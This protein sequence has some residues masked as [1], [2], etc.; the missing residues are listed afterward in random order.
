[1]YSGNWKC[2]V[3]R[4]DASLL[5]LGCFQTWKCILEHML[6]KFWLTYYK[7]CL[8]GLRIFFLQCSLPS[9]SNKTPKNSCLWG[10]KLKCRKT[11]IIGHVPIFTRLQKVKYIIQ[12]PTTGDHRGHAIKNSSCQKK[13]LKQY[14]CSDFTGKVADLVFLLRKE[15]RVL[16]S[17]TK[18]NNILVGT[19]D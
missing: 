5:V 18:N 6:Y 9:C 14:N 12:N 17:Q 4:C 11:D 13:L 19:L 3:K 8:H 15:T 1:M 10:K 16:F 2:V 7:I